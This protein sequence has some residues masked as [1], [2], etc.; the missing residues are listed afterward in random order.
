MS[1]CSLYVVRTGLQEIL[2]GQPLKIDL[3]LTCRCLPPHRWPCSE[4]PSYLSSLR[5]P[6][7]LTFRDYSQG[8][9]QREPIIVGF[10]LWITL[11][12]IGNFPW[13]PSNGPHFL[14]LLLSLAHSFLA[15]WISLKFLKRNTCT[16]SLWSLPA[17]HV[18]V[19]PFTSFRSHFLNEAN[20]PRVIA[21]GRRTPAP[22]PCILPL[23]FPTTLT[24]LRLNTVFTF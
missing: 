15:T 11:T 20:S 24:A 13:V 21:D 5:S 9:I 1:L 23:R 18:L 2:L 3:E 4:P 19:V 6:G 8:D 7:F 12:Q 16:S 22:A 14:T 10:K 17:G